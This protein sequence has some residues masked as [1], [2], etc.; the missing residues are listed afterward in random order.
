LHG[1]KCVKEY[2]RQCSSGTLSNDGCMCSSTY[3]PTCSRGCRLD[4]FGGCICNSNSKTSQYIIMTGIQSLLINAG[5]I[6]CFNGL[7]CSGFGTIV[8]SVLECCNG[9]IGNSH[10]YRIGDGPLYSMVS[11]ENYS[12][13]VIR[14]LLIICHLQ[15]SLRGRNQAFCLF[16]QYSNFKVARV[17]RAFSVVGL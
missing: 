14:E 6:K 8:T 3:T 17:L 1:C 4:V 11:I 2:V 9:Q 12:S 15:F 16:N 13:N 10:S 7:Y 5:G